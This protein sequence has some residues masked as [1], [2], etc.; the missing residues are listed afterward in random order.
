[1][2]HSTFFSHA[3]QMERSNGAVRTACNMHVEG[4]R[5]PGWPNMTWKKLRRMTTVSGSS[6]QF[7]FKKGAPGDQV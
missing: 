7:T 2:P 3:G 4:R 5:R 1:M 6:Q